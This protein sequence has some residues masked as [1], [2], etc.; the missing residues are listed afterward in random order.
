MSMVSSTGRIKASAASA[1]TQPH[2]TGLA[3]SAVA[4]CYSA[5]AK[6]DRHVA[7]RSSSTPGPKSWN[8][9]SCTALLLLAAVLL[10]CVALNAAPLA[11]TKPQDT[12]RT[13]VFL[14]ASP[15]IP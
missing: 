13:P 5:S 10:N 2:R 8:G 7:R 12:D 4:T 3:T 14:V 6:D 15:D 11:T 1:V 9:T